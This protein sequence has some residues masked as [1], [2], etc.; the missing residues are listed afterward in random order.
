MA[1][2]RTRSR[3]GQASKGMKNKAPDEIAAAKEPTKEGAVEDEAIEASEGAETE[4]VGET[5]SEAIEESIAE[6]EAHH[7]EMPVPAYGAPAKEEPKRPKAAWGEPFARVER[8]WTWFE[9]RFLFVLLVMLVLSLVIWIS[10]NGMASPVNTGNSAGTVFRMMV[11]GALVGLASRLATRGRMDPT[12]RSV[13]TTIAVIA[14]V[15]AAPL[16]REVGV[17]GWGRALNWLQEG[18]TLTLFGGLRGV[19]T[20]LTLL[21]ALVGAS[22]AAAS[23]KHIN[24]D[25]VLRFLKPTLRLPVFLLGAVATASVCF[26][27]S[28][29]FFDY[30]SIESFG[31]SREAPAGEKVATV[32][33]EV[34]QHFFILRKQVGLDFGALPK[35][36]SGEPWDDPTRMNGCLLYTSPSPRD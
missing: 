28:W 34:G 22:L 32:R 11:G 14:G 15:A 33:E 10:F 26:F 13:V 25:V 36:L 1:K 6:E 7:H 9:S 17:E 5:P 20:R 19:G 8:G 30:V 35:V 23:G 18:S 24:I 4:P 31:L 29:G 12:K 27:A 2:K 3:E 16:W 21:V